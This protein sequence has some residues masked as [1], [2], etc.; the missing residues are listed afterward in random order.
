MIS[1]LIVDDEMHAVEGVKSSTDWERL[2]IG[3][4]F[5]AYSMKQAQKVFREAAVDIML[6]DIEMPKGSGLDLLRWVREQR[7]D[8]ENL[9]LTSYANFSYANQAIKLGSLDYM[10]KPVSKD[11]LEQA[12]QKSVDRVRE[13]REQ[14]KQIQLAQYWNDIEEQHI[15]QSLVSVINKS[16][17][18]EKERMSRQAEGMHGPVHNSDFYLPVLVRAYDT[19]TAAMQRS[20]INEAVSRIGRK[21]SF[22][23]ALPMLLPYDKNH[24]IIMDV[25][26][27]DLALRRQYIAEKCRE[28]MEQC[29]KQEGIRLACYLGEYVQKD[30]MPGEVARI[31]KMDKE[32]VAEES[33]IFDNLTPRERPVY[34]HP[35]FSDWM[36]QLNGSGSEQIIANSWQYLDRLVSE[37]QINR[38]VLTRFFHD[39][40][41]EIYVAAYRREIQA[42]LLFE[43]EYFEETYQKALMSVENMKHWVAQVVEK[44][45]DYMRVVEGHDS[46]I[47][48]VQQYIREHLDEE[49]GREHLARQVY[50][51]PEYFSRLFRK[52]TGMSLS[53]YIT[54]E[55]IK[56]AKILLRTTGI[57][58]GAVVFQTGYNNCAYF[59]K[60]FKKMTGKTPQQFRNG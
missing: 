56:A 58:V 16:V 3:K 13:K 31:I 21:T 38:D 10:L 2:G 25:W 26:E 6:C 35:P 52:Q 44:V 40:M 29:E 53:D 17:L 33:G 11:I 36:L 54:A 41:Q 48:T 15:Q 19:N 49:L 22:P 51:T 9:F 34:K 4:V 12:L 46:V 20:V 57:S 30:A 18:Q 28:L 60:I 59:S 42:H 1:I 43:E 37:K 32:H 23:E 45:E 8:T 39:F 47:Q 5:T 24:L 27:K 50:L 14:S 7:H 55:R